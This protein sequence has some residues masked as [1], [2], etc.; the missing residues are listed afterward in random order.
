[1]IQDSVTL[2]I[3]FFFWVLK[4]WIVIKVSKRL[5][6]IKEETYAD[7]Y[8][9]MSQLLRSCEDKNRKGGKTNRG[10]YYMHEIPKGMSDDELIMNDVIDF[11]QAFK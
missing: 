8:R 6:L 4:W 10:K 7:R 2:W 3:M 5:G 11:E 9:F 1:M